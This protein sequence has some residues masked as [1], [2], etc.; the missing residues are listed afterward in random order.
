MKK[1]MYRKGLVIGIIVCFVGTGVFPSIIGKSPLN[2]D[3]ID[4]S[5]T[6]GS[7]H[8]QWVYDYFWAAQEFKPTLNVLTRVF[9]MLTKGGNPPNDFI[10]SIRDSK[11]GS[12]LTSVSIPKN[13]IPQYPYY[14]WFEADF[15]DISVVPQNSYY[16]VVSSTGG[17]TG[18]RFE[19]CASAGDPYPAGTSHWSEN[20][21][22]NW[23]TILNVDFCFKTYGYNQQGNLPPSVSITY[24]QNGDTVSGTITITGTASDPNGNNDLNYVMV[25][26]PG[27]G[28]QT[29]S[30]TSSWSYE[31]DTTTVDDGE[32][33]ISAICSDGSLQSPVVYVVFDVK[34]GGAILSFSPKTYNLYLTNGENYTTT[35]SIWNSGTDTLIYNILENCNWINIYPTYG[36]CIEQPDT[37]TVDIDTTYLSAGVHNCEISVKSNGGNESLNI[38]ISCINS[39]SDWGDSG[40]FGDDPGLHINYYIHKEDDYI[41]SENKALAD[42]SISN[43]LPPV[44]Q[45]TAWACIGVEC[46]ALESGMHNIKMEGNCRGIFGSD[47]ISF[48]EVDNWIDI[49]LNVIEK[50]IYSPGEDEGKSIELYH[51][52]STFVG[53]LVEEDFNGNI[54]AYLSKGKTYLIYLQLRAHAAT[55]QKYWYSWSFLAGTDFGGPS[56]MRY[57]KYSSIEIQY[58]L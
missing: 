45:G 55:L 12:D 40:Y 27:M 44:K 18:N 13:N 24:P 56:N 21:G 32:H 20:Y 19:W 47:G 25:Q 10:V 35:F 43:W 6:N 33:I 57:A 23:G 53:R 15:D 36:F 58:N 28:W 31:W 52:D 38:T 37:I 3:Q 9:L 29:A 50:E 34:N 16:I 4:Q 5:Q 54:D 46:I 22:H 30:G 26:P 39:E 48:T 8:T 7:D 51:E 11:S 42:V 2:M 17:D 41:K 1:S 14:D 49:S